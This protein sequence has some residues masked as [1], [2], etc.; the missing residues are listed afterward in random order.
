MAT[1]TNTMALWRE[2]FQLALQALRANKMRSILTMLGVVIGTASIVLVVTIAL[3]GKRYILAQ[4]EGVGSNLVYAHL[5]ASGGQEPVVFADRITPADRAAVQEGL[6][7]LVTATAG[8]NWLPTTMDIAGHDRV[9]NLVGVTNGFEQIRNLQVVSGRYFD[10]DDLASESKV[11][12]LTEALARR[13]TPVGDPVGRDVQ[14]GELHF[15]VIG[16]FRERVATLGDSELTRESVLI[17][18]PLIKSYTGSDYFQ[19]LYAKT[20][21]ADDVPVVT[22]EVEEILQSRHRPGAHYRADNLSGILETARNVAWGLTMVLVLVALIALVISGIGIMNIMLVTVTERTREIGIRKAIGAT[23]DAIRYQF[24]MEAVVISGMGA[25]AGILIAIAIPLL[26]N[27][28][29][30]F[31]P[32]AGDVSVQVSWVSVALAFIVSCSTGLVFG[33]LPANRAAGLEP[34]RSLHYE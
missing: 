26:L 21:S 12:L 20:D 15:T 4:I 19:T 1:T 9:V 10:P 16:V 23:R 6:P 33:Y 2:I 3:S 31:I 25:L 13:I 24:L 17:P 11:C 18:F 30:R 7:T 34:A 27:F 29:I 22:R 32:D 14:V 28:L 8:S 5:V